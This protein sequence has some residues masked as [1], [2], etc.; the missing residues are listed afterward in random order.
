MQKKII[1][2]LIILFSISGCTQSNSSEKYD[3]K[4]ES[5]SIIT[6]SYEN[7]ES[8]LLI[9]Q[10][11]I[12]SK[13]EEAELNFDKGSHGFDAKSISTFGTV[14]SENELAHSIRVYKIDFN[15]K[16]KVVINRKHFSS[17]PEKYSYYL[18]I[19]IMRK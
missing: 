4:G 10:F 18:P 14:Y 15:K 13:N 6:T 3:P 2:C 8:Y 11:F 1:I 7:G 12:P 9:N 19:E 5:L 16:S 17:F